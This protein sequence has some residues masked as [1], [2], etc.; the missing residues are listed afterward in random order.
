MPAR[1]KKEKKVEIEVP[2]GT[3]RIT[4]KLNTGVNTKEYVI[5]HLYMKHNEDGKEPGTIHSIFSHAGD[6]LMKSVIKDMNPKHYIAS[7]K[8]IIKEWH[9]F[10]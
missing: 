3:L 9:L 6:P 2:K 10:L 4:P 1:K 7:R 5:V 8:K